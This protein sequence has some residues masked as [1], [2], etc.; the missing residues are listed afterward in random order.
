LSFSSQYLW[1]NSRKVYRSLAASTLHHLILN[2]GE[3]ETEGAAFAIGTAKDHLAI[4]ALND[5]LD[6][7]QA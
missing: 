4:V 7:V 3:F 2:C 6:Q 5:V 1:E